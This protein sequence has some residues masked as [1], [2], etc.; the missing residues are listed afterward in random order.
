MDIS[1][2]TDEAHRPI[3]PACKDTDMCWVW[4]DRLVKYLKC[5]NCGFDTNIISWEKTREGRACLSDQLK[6]NQAKDKE[7]SGKLPDPPDQS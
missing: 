6:R 1:I 3:C 4:G 5:M 7:A 2:Q